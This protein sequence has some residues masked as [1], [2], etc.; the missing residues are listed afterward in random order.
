MYNIIL[1]DL[2]LNI[3]PNSSFHHPSFSGVNKGLQV[4]SQK[5]SQGRRFVLKTLASIPFSIQNLLSFRQ[6]NISAEEAQKVIKLFFDNLGRSRASIAN[7]TQKINLHNK[8]HSEAYELDQE[9]LA[10]LKAN[11]SKL[12]ELEQVF[13][14][15]EEDFRKFTASGL[16]NQDLNFAQ[17]N[18]EW[19]LK[20]PHKSH[21]HDPV[22][23]IF[24]RLQSKI[25]ELPFKEIISAKKNLFGLLSP[26]KYQGRTTG[27][28]DS[29][30][31]EEV[32][33]T[34]TN[35]FNNASRI[36]FRLRQN[37]EKKAKKDIKQTEETEMKEKKAQKRV[38]KTIQHLTW[39]ASKRSLA[40]QIHSK[41][42]Y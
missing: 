10:G 21:V 35:Q 22:I 31:Q 24:D 15:Y 17:K 28:L 37:Q 9:D 3:N 2:S 18:L 34:I 41:Q 11:F 12:A 38:K 14:R 4:F 20:S 5:F 1:M 27:F 39:G 6:R 23:K 36:S 7:L 19:F 8:D 26:L 32:L 30:Q 40:S 42:N 29:Q 16:F 25:L 13:H 33:R